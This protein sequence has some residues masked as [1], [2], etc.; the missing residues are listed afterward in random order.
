MIG[1]FCKGKFII[2]I[3]NLILFL[4][5]SFSAALAQ[6]VHLPPQ[7]K[8][9]SGLLFMAKDSLLWINDSGNPSELYLTDSIGKLG[10]TYKLPLRNRDWEDLAD[11]PMG[12]IYIG[13]FGNNCHCRKDL[14][15][16]ILSRA[17]SIDSI[18][19][20]YPEQIFP[21]KG[22]QRA[23]NAEAFYWRND[24]LH[25]FTKGDIREKNF[26]TYHYVLPAKAGNYFPRLKETI[27]LKNRV[28]TAAAVSPSG[29]KMALLTY[30]YGL[31]LG[32]FPYSKADIFLFNEG[33]DFS[34]QTARRIKIK[35]RI[36]P[37]QYEAIDFVDE[38][39]LMVGSEKTPFFKQQFRIL[40]IE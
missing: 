7:L 33:T 34:S 11:D 21:T 37:S 38:N 30:R 19:F 15:I 35:P 27:L 25:I 17:G 4:S 26:F 31:F 32:I 8:E 14:R 16:Y 36:R 2:R 22:K 6:Q 13:D 1:N 39:K 5:G 12:N 10:S 23:Y 20:S 18:L 3:I 9:A 40:P 29:E 24:S 28:A